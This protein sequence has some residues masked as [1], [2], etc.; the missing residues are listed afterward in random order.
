MPGDGYKMMMSVLVR[1]KKKK[2]LA[3]PLTGV[4]RSRGTTE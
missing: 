1:V 2:N 4:A 3:E